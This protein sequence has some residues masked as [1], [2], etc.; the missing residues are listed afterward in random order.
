MDMV[1]RDAD[2]EEHHQHDQRQNKAD[3]EILRAVIVAGKISV[4]SVGK[5]SVK[6]R[7]VNHDGEIVGVG[8]TRPLP[9][10]GP[11]GLDPMPT[12]L[13][14]P[15]PMLERVIEQWGGHRDLWLFGYGSLIWKPESGST[16]SRR[17]AA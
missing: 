14:D 5:G 13:R 17:M 9:D 10:P 3:D 1:D 7:L 2:D 15:Q 16:A 11:P 4:R 8:P 12:P 6:W